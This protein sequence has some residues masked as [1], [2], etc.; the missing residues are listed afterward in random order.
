M[1]SLE[2]VYTAC[3]FFFCFYRE[4]GY[5]EGEYKRQLYEAGLSDIY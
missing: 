4:N 5:N 1:L 2:H 3:S